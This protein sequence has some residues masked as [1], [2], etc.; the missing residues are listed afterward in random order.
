MK[1]VHGKVLRRRK[2][3]TKETQVTSQFYK[4]RKQLLT[5]RDVDKLLKEI[6][7]KGEK[8]FNNFSIVRIFVQNGEKKSTWLDWEEFEE[9]YEG[10]VKDVDKFLEFTQVSVTCVY[11]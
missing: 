1:N 10:K 11:S 8:D 4:G 3:N 6:T 5:K 7:T 9:Y 2:L